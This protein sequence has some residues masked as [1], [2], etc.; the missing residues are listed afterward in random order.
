MAQQFDLEEAAE[1]VPL[2]CSKAVVERRGRNVHL[3]GEF[4]AGKPLR[5]LEVSAVIRKLDGLALTVGESVE[6]GLRSVL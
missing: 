1:E 3:R 5:G 6:D 4:G 2:C